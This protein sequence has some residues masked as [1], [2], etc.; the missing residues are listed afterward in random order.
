MVLMMSLLLQTKVYQDLHLQLKVDQHLS[1]LM[2]QVF[3]SLIHFY[4]LTSN[5]QDQIDLQHPP[6][7]LCF[8]A[9]IINFGCFI[10]VFVLVAKQVIQNLIQRIVK[11]MLQ[12][13]K[14]IKTLQTCLVFKEKV[15]T[16]SYL[17][18]YYFVVVAVTT[19]PYQMEKV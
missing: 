7:C 9:T 12:M 10:V 8:Q 5:C 15:R 3:Q 14:L 19:D 2:L 11:I 16:C 13:K 1:L 17:K 4:L 6:I 18:T